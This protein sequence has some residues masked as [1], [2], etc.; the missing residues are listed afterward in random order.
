MRMEKEKGEFED[1]KRKKAPLI[2]CLQIGKGESER[3][4]TK[5]KG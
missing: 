1:R 4:Y 2:W 5:K 3:H